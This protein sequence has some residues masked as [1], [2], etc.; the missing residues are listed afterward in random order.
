MTENGSEK[1]L[2]IYPKCENGKMVREEK[3]FKKLREKSFCELL[4]EKNLN[5]LKRNFLK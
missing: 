5:F 3:S 4:R 2:G 1:A